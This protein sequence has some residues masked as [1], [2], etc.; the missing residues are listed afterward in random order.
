MKKINP[1]LSALLI[2]LYSSPMN[3]WADKI[4]D[5]IIKR[6]PGATLT[7]ASGISPS[8]PVH[9]GNLRDIITIGFVGKALQE[10]GVPIR[11]IHSWD[12]YDRFRKVPSGVPETYQEFIGKPLSKVPDPFGCHKSYAA[13][14][15]VAFET[16]LSELGIRVEFIYQTER[17]E[18]GIY[19][20]A[21]REAVQKREAIYEILS[22]FKTE[23]G[24]GKETYFPF[25][26]YCERCDK[27]TSPRPHP[28][29][30][31]VFSYTC[32]AC[33]HD[34]EV[35]LRT[36]RNLKLPWKVDWAIRWR[37]EGVVFEP[38]GKDHAT[39]GGSFEVSSEIAKQVFHYDPPIFQ[40]YEFIGLKGLT[41]KMSG[42][43]GILLTPQD[44]LKI[45]QP[46]VLLWVF[47]KIAPNKAFNLVLDE[48]IYRVYDEFDKA[49]E[50]PADRAIQ[51]SCRLDHTPHPAPFK[52]LASFSGIVHKNYEAMEQIF[53]RLGTPHKKKCFQ[54]RL[55]KAEQWLER[56]AP[57]QRMTLL[58]TRHDAY[59]K[60]LTPEEQDWIVQLHDWLKT[61]KPTLDEATQKVYDIPK[62]GESERTTAQRRFFQIVYMLLFGKEKGPRL[63]TFF[64]A[65]PTEDY[66]HLLCF[67]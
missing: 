24:S 9:V 4:A 32:R 52:S 11:L 26:I 46:E 61:E 15:E 13:H 55:L 12:D 63:G 16:A 14:H 23:E 58:S 29:N 65:V 49:R 41:G 10:R 20:E 40:P 45:Y 59:F 66:L 44:A 30:E 39:A 35:D 5:T 62:A 27:E 64:A 51:L 67:R 1:L 47:A 3:H 54:E 28:D 17:Y 2:G 53:S 22:L 18:S 48:G 37:H 33:R 6:H 34:G 60:T 56:Y 50:D 36:A 31:M 8:G 25:T 42:S 43:S 7:C 21:I 19:L 38:G 57:E